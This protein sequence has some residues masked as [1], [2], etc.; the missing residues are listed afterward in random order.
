[1]NSEQAIKNLRRTIWDLSGQKEAQA[2]RVLAYLKVRVNRDKGLVVLPHSPK[3]MTFMEAIK[4]G[5][6]RQQGNWKD[7]PW[8]FDNR[9]MPSATAALDEAN[10]HLKAHW[11]E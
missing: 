11:A 1:M 5:Y 7:A 8:V 10:R 3:P 4:L 9:I 6:I 2:E